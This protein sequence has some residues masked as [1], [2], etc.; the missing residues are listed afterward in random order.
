MDVSVGKFCKFYDHKRTKI[1]LFKEVVPIILDKF[2]SVFN[3]KE[4]IGMKINKFHLPLHLENTQ[5]CQ[6]NLE[7]QTAKRQI[8]SLSIQAAYQ[9]TFPR[10]L[11]QNDVD[12]I[13][14]KT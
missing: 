9:Q 4:G 5:R 10:E 6:C 12:A 13:E 3:R 2:K 14:N 11:D 1:L 7:F 8:D